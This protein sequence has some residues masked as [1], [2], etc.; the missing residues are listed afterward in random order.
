MPCCANRLRIA[1]TQVPSSAI[2]WGSPLVPKKAPNQVGGHERANIDFSLPSSH[3]RIDDAEAVWVAFGA[4][5]GVLRHRRCTRPLG[6]SHRGECGFR[7]LIFHF[8]TRLIFDCSGSPRE[9]TQPGMDWGL[10]CLSVG[11]SN[12][13]SLANGFVFSDSPW[14]RFSCSEHHVPFGP[15]GCVLWIV[16]GGRFL[17]SENIEQQ[18]FLSS[19]KSRKLV[20]RHQ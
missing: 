6:T 2:V 13:C 14:T 12:R 20:A 8:L 11:G 16:F 4:S 18:S 17:G 15:T 5:T 9:T 10:A 1:G 7:Y 19:R 3:E